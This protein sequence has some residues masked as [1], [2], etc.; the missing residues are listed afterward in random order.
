M[1][2][3]P[4]R[5]FGQVREIGRRVNPV[6]S[7]EPHAPIAH[8]GLHP[9]AVPFDLVSP[10][11]IVEGRIGQGRQHRWDEVG[12]GR[13]LSLSEVRLRLNLRGRAAETRLRAGRDLVVGQSALHAGGVL[14][15]IPAVD[16]RL[17]SLVDQQPLSRVAGAPQG[18]AP[19]PRLHDREAATQSLP[20][21]SELQLALLQGRRRVIGL[22][23]AEGPPVPDDHVAGAVFALRNDSLKVQILDRVILG[24]LREAPPIGI[25]RRAARHS[26]A[27]QHAADL[28]AQVVMEPGGAVTLDHEPAAPLPWW[29]GG[30]LRRSREVALGPIC[31][32]RHRPDDDRRPQHAARAHDLPAA[33]MGGR[34]VQEVHGHDHDPPGS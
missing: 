11:G 30:R 2:V 3:D 12:Q 32:E 29:T 14:L 8:H 1:R 33:S 10:G 13:T 27:D 18:V 25:E 22:L 15:R 6:P 21:Q 31:L 9:V 7:P 34:V 28:Q 23:G 4:V 16:R 20:V 5:C 17:V 26:P 24:A 19:T